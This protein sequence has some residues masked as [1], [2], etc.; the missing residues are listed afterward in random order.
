[1]TSA[2]DGGH[3]S[4]VTNATF[5]NPRLVYTPTSC[6]EGVLDG[7]WWPHTRVLSEELPPLLAAVASRFGPVARISL[8][9][10]AWDATPQDITCGDGVVQV[11]WY[12]SCDAD[13]IRLLGSEHWQGETTRGVLGTVDAGAGAGF[14]GGAQVGSEH[15]NVLGTGGF[16]V[17]PGLGFGG[18][19]VQHGPDGAPTYDAG[20][21]GEVDEFTVGGRIHH[22]SDGR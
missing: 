2:L 18:Y 5:A 11:A 3:G 15:T 10:T 20:G 9:T 8:N 22:Q 7:A 12:R 19:A 4:P 6:A 21:S 1:M 14:T 17:G 16:G 13:T